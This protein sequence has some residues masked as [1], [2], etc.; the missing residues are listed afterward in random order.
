MMNM[1]RNSF[2]CVRMEIKTH[3]LRS[4]FVHLPY[5]YKVQKASSVKE[6]KGL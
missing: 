1:K 2:F 6:T 3:P 4:P 5:Y